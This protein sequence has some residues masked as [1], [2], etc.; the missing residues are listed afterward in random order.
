MLCQVWK[1]YVRQWWPG[2]SIRTCNQHWI[3]GQGVRVS[4]F[5][6][7][8]S[9]KKYWDLPYFHKQMLKNV[10]L[11]QR[12]LEFPLPPG[13]MFSQVWKSYARHT[14]QKMKFPIKDFISKCDQI[15][16]KL[17]IWSHFL[18]KSLMENFMF[19]AVAAVTK[20]E[21]ANLQSTLNKR[22]RGASLKIFVTDSR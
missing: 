14:A 15:C 18:K 22:A 10:R 16:R 5:L 20:S 11:A 6:W 3:R 2:M 9:H 8:I 21:Q 13:S 4:Q 19:C 17:R 12:Y 7:L 1:S